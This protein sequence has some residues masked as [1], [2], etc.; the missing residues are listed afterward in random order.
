[1]T[2]TEE[3]A[4]WYLE[5][6]Q[7]EGCVRR[8]L[9]VLDDTVLA[10]STHCVKCERKL[11]VLEMYQFPQINYYPYID[12][13]VMLR[14]LG[15]DMQDSQNWFGVIWV[16]PLCSDCFERERND[17]DSESVVEL[18]ECDSYPVESLEGYVKE[19][20]S[21]NAYV[22]ERPAFAK[23]LKHVNDTNNVIHALQ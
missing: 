5:E 10:A 16:R 3:R 8:V 7:N 17:D 11:F 4:R 15:V 6:V 18:C 23:L 13:K 20:K 21:S 22:L 9:Y 12:C 2:L 1:M 19:G 14:Y